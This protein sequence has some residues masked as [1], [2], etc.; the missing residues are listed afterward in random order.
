M[1]DRIF[2]HK[3]IWINY[4]TY[5]VRL[6]QDSLNPRTH[7]DIMVLSNEDENCDEPHPYWYARIIGIYHVDV[8]HNLRGG[9]RSLAGEPVRIDLLWVRWFG[10]HLDHR[11]GWAARR[12][13]RVGF[14]ELDEE[15]P[16]FGFLHP[17]QVV[18]GA[19]LIPAFHHGRTADLLPPSIA[20]PESNNDEDWRFYYVNW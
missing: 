12:L 20:R 5:D 10:R 17:S 8:I 15:T 3:V 4:T 11:A 16:A 2:I 7:A 6:A 13:H 1:N 19:H 14:V 9:T 18:R